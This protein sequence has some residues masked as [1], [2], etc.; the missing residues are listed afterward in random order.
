MRNELKALRAARTLSQGQLAIAV[1]VSRQTIYA[2]ENGRS[3][4]SL[5]VALALARF[6]GRSVEDVF[7]DDAGRTPPRS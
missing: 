1:G 5:S 4:P 2:V 6:F 3:E 7:H